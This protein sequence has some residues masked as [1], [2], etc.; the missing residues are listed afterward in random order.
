LLEAILA[1]YREGANIELAGGDI[2][3]GA[4]AI[5]SLALLLHE[6]A[7][8]ATK[9]G[10]LSAPGGRVSISCADQGDDLVLTWIERGGPS[11]KRRHKEGFGSLLVR[12]TVSGQL[13][14][15]A[16][17][18]WKSEGLTITLSI[19]RERLG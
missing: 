14:G 2:P 13:G 11:V 10:A 5:T 17:Y 19:P 7:T 15:R 12:T 4:G 1:P 3:I 18:D 8:N 6:F 9:Y 16:S